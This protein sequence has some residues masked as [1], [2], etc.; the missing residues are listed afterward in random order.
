MKVN[1]NPKVVEALA[2]KEPGFSTTDVILQNITVD[3]TGERIVRESDL[4]SL[5]EFKANAQKDFLFIIQTL[6]NFQTKFS[7]MDLG[8]KVKLA[9][10]AARGKF[11]PS[12]IGIDADR[13][14]LIGQRY[15]PEYTQKLISTITEKKNGI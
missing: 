13:F 14:L 15:A 1:V 7:E 5:I 11:D 9:I 4:Q 3:L 2:S 10:K 8:D 12:F 6:E